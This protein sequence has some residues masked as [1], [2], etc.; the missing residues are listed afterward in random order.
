[1]FG[2][3]ILEVAIGLAFM[4]FALST[5]ASHVNE[6]VASILSWRAKDLERGITNLLAD[7]ATASGVWTHPLIARLGSQ[8]R[9]LMPRLGKPYRAPSYIPAATF[10]LALFDTVSD[11]NSADIAKVRDAISRL[12]EA[13][14]QRA[15]LAIIDSAEG[16]VARAKTAVGDWF[17]AAMERLSGE[18][19]R[20][21]LW[22]TLLISA[23]VAAAIGADSIA[24]AQSLWQEEGIR[25][26]L[27]A[28]AQ[29]QSNAN[30]Q[31]VLRVL[32]GIGLPLGWG[33]LPNTPDGWALKA[34]GILITTIAVSLG[35]PFWFDF[36][37]KFSNPRSSGGKPSQ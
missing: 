3:S 31:D 21:I 9:G 33:H 16:D 25:A 14:A 18:Y 23:L 4:Y 26:A 28:A 30:G 13:S 22:F 11:G 32:S 6:R 29:N 24:L 10:A 5:V 15:L 8:R 19:K 36:L 37:Q 1:M 35:A 27:V 34:A 17:N 2:S 7:P 20:R 12:P